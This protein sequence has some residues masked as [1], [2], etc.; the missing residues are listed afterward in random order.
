MKC[1]C[2][3]NVVINNH[4][5]DCFINYFES[6][7][8]KGAGN[9]CGKSICVAVSGGKDSL[10]TLYL[11][12]KF[13]PKNKVLALLINEGIKGYREHTIKSLK[14]YVKE[15]G[16]PYKIVNFKKELDNIKGA[17]PCSVCGVLRR[18]YLNKHARNY[19]VLVTGHNLDDEAQA[20]LMNVFM[21]YASRFKRMTNPLVN[22]YLFVKRVKPLRSLSEREVM[23]YFM[24]KGFETPMNECPYARIS[25]RDIVRTALNEFELK[26]PNS[27]L[28][29][30][31]TYDSLNIISKN[32][33]LGSCN[34]CGEPSSN[35]VCEACQI[36]NY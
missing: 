5:R 26:H 10:T 25:F 23:A 33:S 18:Y 4:C 24:L 27:K 32:I 1:K 9:L 13:Y 3:R 28:N 31:K 6:E 2:K 16:V 20:T 7:F 19:D 30:I 29:I 11:I 8:K 35:E 12:K 15:W 17:R 21:R 34:D 22:H 14:K 36:L